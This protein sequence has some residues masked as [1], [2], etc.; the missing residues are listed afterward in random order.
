MRWLLIFVLACGHSSPSPGNPPPDGKAGGDGGSGGDAGTTIDGPASASVWTPHPGTSW[1]WQLQGTIDTSFDVMMYDIDLFDVPQGTIDD[2]HAAGR[3]VICYLSAGT[4]EPGRPDSADFPSSVIGNELPDW[5][6][7]HWLDTRSS[8]VRD[9]MKARLDRAVTRQCDGVE[10]D[11]I[12]GYQNDPGFPLTATTQL[13][14]N[15]FLATEAHARGLSVGLKNDL[16]Q[17]SDLLPAFD[18][19]LNEQCF[20]YDECAM[21]DPFVAANKAVFQVEYGS[22]SLATTV[23]PRANAENFDTLIKPANEEVTAWR[24][25][26]R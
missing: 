13:D 24:V 26:C 3:R 16:D 8:A 23:C 12:D 4:Y 15:R 5:P 14:Y 1:Q 17:V 6:G 25:A 19:A 21:L 10:P 20:Q 18:W 2:L 11:N 7:E 22:A 9:L